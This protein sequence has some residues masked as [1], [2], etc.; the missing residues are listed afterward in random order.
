MRPAERVNVRTTQDIPASSG[1]T[2]TADGFTPISDL[3]ELTDGT[4]MHKDD[5]PRHEP[6]NEK[7]RGR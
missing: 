3:V 2:P 7:L 6:P 1:F 4:V 5:M